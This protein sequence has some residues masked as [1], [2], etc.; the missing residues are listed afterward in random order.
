MKLQSVEL[1]LRI[2][3]RR[4]VGALRSPGS[5]KSFRQRRHFVAMTVPDIDLWAESIQQLRAVCDVQRP[6]A[7]LASPGEHNLAAKVMCYQ[8]QAITNAEHRNAERKDFWIEMRRVFVVNTCRTTGENE[9][10]RFQLGDF[11]CGCVE[12]NNLRINL[13]FTNAPRNDLCVLG[14]EIEN[15]DS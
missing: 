15:E 5:A 13:Q 2:F 1:A 10:V 6:S 12:A 8:H 9:S 4:E 14:T 3:H 11:S 7:V